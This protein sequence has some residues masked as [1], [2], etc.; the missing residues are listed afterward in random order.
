MNDLS[1]HAA[2]SPDSEYTLS[3][4]EAAKRYEHAGPPRTDRTI[5][6]YCAEGHLDCHRMEPP[7]GEKYLITPASVGKHIAYIE[8]VLSA[9]HGDAGVDAGARPPASTASRAFEVSSLRRAE[10]TAALRHSE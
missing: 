9:R 5:Q 7:F 8:E 2:T 10:D 6:R 4:E 3:I 1:R